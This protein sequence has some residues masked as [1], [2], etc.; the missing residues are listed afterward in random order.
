MVQGVG[1]A[2][3]PTLV[4]VTTT[5]PRNSPVALSVPADVTSICA[6][7]KSAFAFTVGGSC[8]GSSAFGFALLRPQKQYCHRLT[9]KESGWWCASCR[10]VRYSAVHVTPMSMHGAETYFCALGGRYQ[11][12]NPSP[13]RYASTPLFTP[14]PS[15]L[16]TTPVQ[17]SFV[18]ISAS[19]ELGKQQPV[20]GLRSQLHCKA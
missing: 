20:D 1:T 9:C 3:G 13:T 12:V 19:Q 11:G 17:Q 4:A 5:L 7:Q 18:T 8:D 2:T 15:A 10:Y 6:W 16:S 14:D